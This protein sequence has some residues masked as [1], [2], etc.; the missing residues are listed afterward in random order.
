MASPVW[1]GEKFVSRELDRALMICWKVE[2][3]TKPAVLQ[4]SEEDTG[5]KDSGGEA[6]TCRSDR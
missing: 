5:K 2:A 6:Q 1:E 4:G 3:D